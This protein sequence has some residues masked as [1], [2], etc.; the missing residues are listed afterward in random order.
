MG[1]NACHFGLC[2]LPSGRGAWRGSRPSSH[3]GLHAGNAVQF[4]GFEL[5]RAIGAISILVGLG[6]LLGSF[7]RF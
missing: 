1:T 5:T 2:S 7:A 3:G 4:F 6:A